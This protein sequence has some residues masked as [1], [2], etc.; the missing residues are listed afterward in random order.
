MLTKEKK[1]KVLHLLKERRILRVPRRTKKFERRV[2]LEEFQSQNVSSTAQ[3]ELG[4]RGTGAGHFSQ[5]EGVTSPDKKMVF[6]L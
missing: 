5:M 6:R 2:K 1:G 4:M 3:Q